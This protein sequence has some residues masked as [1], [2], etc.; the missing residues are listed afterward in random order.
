MV[1]GNITTQ[2]KQSQQAV[3]RAVYLF[4][5]YCE[6]VLI[7]QKQLIFLCRATNYARISINMI[8]PRY[9]LLK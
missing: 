9:F 4:L 1:V 5:V 3:T 6:P 7:P 2:A 8:E